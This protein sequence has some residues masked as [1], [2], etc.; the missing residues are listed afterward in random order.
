MSKNR[1]GEIYEEGPE[2]Q[3]ACGFGTADDPAKRGGMDESGGWLYSFFPP[4][5]TEWVEAK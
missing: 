5:G 1:H 4:H 3:V 2:K